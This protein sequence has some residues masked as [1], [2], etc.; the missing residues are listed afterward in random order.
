[1]SKYAAVCLSHTKPTRTI[2]SCDNT[3]APAAL[4]DTISD[5]ESGSVDVD[6]VSD[7][8]IGASVHIDDPSDYHP[9]DDSL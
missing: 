4:R 7:D 9:I 6:H 2:N 5:D 8:A 3:A 1:M